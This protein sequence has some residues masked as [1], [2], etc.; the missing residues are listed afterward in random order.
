MLANSSR[1][2]DANSYATPLR[3]LS[4]TF[5]YIVDFAKQSPHFGWKDSLNQ[6]EVPFPTMQCFV[7]RRDQSFASMEGLPH[8][9]SDHRGERVC[10]YAG[11]LPACYKDACWYACKQLTYQSL[12]QPN[13]WIRLMLRWTSSQLGIGF[14][15]LQAAFRFL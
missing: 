11:K 6:V 12:P 4:M 5:F 1:Q 15:Q 13:T 9:L 10:R 14:N 8:L 7:E 2:V 3:A